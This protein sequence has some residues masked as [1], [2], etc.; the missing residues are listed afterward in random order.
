VL[1]ASAQDWSRA[2]GRALAVPGP[3]PEG[4]D[5]HPRAGGP[6]AEG[7]PPVR[8]P[9]IE[10]LYSHGCPCYPEAVALVERVRDELGVT[11]EVRAV[12]VGDQEAAER[13]RFPGSPTVRV[14]GG[15]VE[16]GADPPT[17]ITI[18]CRLYRHP[19]R[20][21]GQPPEQWVRDALLKAIDRA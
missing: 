11:S 4:T 18:D 5:G 2:T 13:A 17:E 1:P 20:L 16:P 10:V 6:V 21:A 19:H 3:T 12:L 8:E 15:D 7:R 14:D 9:V